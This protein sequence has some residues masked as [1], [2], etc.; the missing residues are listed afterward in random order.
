MD[1]LRQ[2]APP[3]NSSSSRGSKC[4][5]KVN[6]DRGGVDLFPTQ[7][8]TAVSCTRTVRVESTRFFYK[9]ASSTVTITAQPST[10]TTTIT[11]TT[12]TTSSIGS[13]PT[14]ARTTVTSSITTTALTTTTQVSTVSST[15]TNTVTVNAPTVTEYAACA[16]NNTVSRVNG[17][18][19]IYGIQDLLVAIQAPTAI[20]CCITCQTTMNCTTAAYYG[21]DGTCL[22]GNATGANA[23]QFYTTGS[24]EN[25]DTI[26]TLSNGAQSLGNWLW[27]GLIDQPLKR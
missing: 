18:S 26:F 6:E 17:N 19:I 8:P 14:I 2:E 9:T 13:D 3:P 15:I 20:E 5:F 10:S 25:A 22:L 27:E 11:S 12:T 16:A 7:N 4:S 21:D 23:N 24:A 1:L